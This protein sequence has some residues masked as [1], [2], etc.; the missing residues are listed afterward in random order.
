[1]PSRLW[2]A[3]VAL[4][5][6][7]TACGNGDEGNGAQQEPVQEEPTFAQEDLPEIVLQESEAPEGTTFSREDSGPITL[8][9]AW[10]SNCCQEEQDA[11][12]AAGF[13]AAHL[14]VF[15]G[16]QGG[17][18]AFVLSTAMLF[19]DP[20]GATESVG[21]AEGWISEDEQA[22]MLL[23]GIDPG[24]PTI[25][26][27]PTQGLGDD[28]TGIAVSG[29]SERGQDIQAIVMFWRVGNVSLQARGVGFVEAFGPED[30]RAIADTMSSD[31]PA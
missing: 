20:A 14:S 10:E 26:P 22:P 23:L 30:V 18:F 9:E 11:V 31:L 21:V 28:A 4:L 2:V 19:E 24:D 27:V 3:S 5:L 16:E 25:E 7:T 8:E 6:I 13:Q 29:T 17:T 15:G 1:M 12:G